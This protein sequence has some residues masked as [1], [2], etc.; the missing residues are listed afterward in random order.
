[1]HG[2][3]K[4][5]CRLTGAQERAAKN[6]FEAKNGPTGYHLI[7]LMAASDAVLDTV[8]M[9]AGRP[10]LIVGKKLADSKHEL[11]KLLSAIH[12]FQND[13]MKEPR[14]NRLS[15]AGVLSLRQEAPMFD[16]ADVIKTAIHSAFVK[17]P[18]EDDPDFSPHWIKPEECAHLTKVIMVEL[19]ANG[20]EIVK[21]GS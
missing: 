5:V 11:W 13:Q 4:A 17:H 20:F 18:M 12:D 1:M 15:A 21:K 3:V 6:W 2:A 9:A 16:P 10:D 14:D 8:L 7:A 19:E